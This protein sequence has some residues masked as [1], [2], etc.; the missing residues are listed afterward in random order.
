MDRGCLV[1]DEVV[2]PRTQAVMDAGGVTRSV[3]EAILV[4][5]AGV[6]GPIERQ[7][8]ADVGELDTLTGAR[9]SYAQMA[10]RLARAL[11]VDTDEITSLS[12]AS[13]EL[14]AALDEIWKGVRV[15]RPSDRAVAGLDQPHGGRS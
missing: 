15:E 8:R 9:R 3:A 7:V 13:R 5:L 14:R 11:D 4:A 6:P 1:V 12:G 2:D 10:Y